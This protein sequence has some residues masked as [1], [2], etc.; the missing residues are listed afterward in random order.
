MTRIHV[1]THV[2]VDQK[3]ETCG[4]IS[5]VVPPGCAPRTIS[6]RAKWT[7]SV[8]SYVVTVLSG[9]RI[10]VRGREGARDHAL[11]CRRIWPNP[12]TLSVGK[13]GIIHVLG[14][15]RSSQR[16]A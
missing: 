16:V 1:G 3:M 4:V 15:N 9:V 13:K 2:F 6:H 10:H 5:E 8:E 12:E 14:I 7:R 11:G